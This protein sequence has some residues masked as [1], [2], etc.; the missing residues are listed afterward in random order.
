LSGIK[1]E[2]EA[3]YPKIDSHH[4]EQSRLRARSDRIFAVATR[5]ANIVLEKWDKREEMLVITDRLKKIISR[6]PVASLIRDDLCHIF[7]Q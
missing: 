4:F 6:S 1:A 5:K 2:L 3:R 7:L